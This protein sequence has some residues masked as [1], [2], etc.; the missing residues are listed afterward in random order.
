M[1]FPISYFSVIICIESGS[2][3]V[4]VVSVIV[5]DITVVVHVM[6]VV[7]IVSRP[8][9]PVVGLSVNNPWFINDDIIFDFIFPRRIKV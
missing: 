7:G 5:V 2:H 6:E 3:I 1:L 4:R 8:Q 9:P